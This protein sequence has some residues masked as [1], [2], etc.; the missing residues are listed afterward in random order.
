[1]LWPLL[2]LLPVLPNTAPNWITL[3]AQV[4]VVVVAALW[5]RSVLNS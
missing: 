2:P 3:M 1:M 4:V 5:L